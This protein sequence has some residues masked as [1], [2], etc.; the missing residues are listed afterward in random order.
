VDCQ[1][2]CSASVIVVAHPETAKRTTAVINNLGKLNGVR[3]LFL[4]PPALANTSN[5]YLIDLLKGKLIE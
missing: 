2:C 3:L 4:W 1:T 5:W